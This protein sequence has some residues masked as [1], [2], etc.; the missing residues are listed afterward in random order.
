MVNFQ[1]YETYS[2]VWWDVEDLNLH[3]FETEAHSID[4]AWTRTLALMAEPNAEGW[5]PKK[6]AT[7]L[8]FIGR[9][10]THRRMMVTTPDS[11]LIL[12]EV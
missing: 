6:G 9:A 12:K 3:L 1:A 2:F 8:V 5:G 4:D 10:V 11:P 7:I